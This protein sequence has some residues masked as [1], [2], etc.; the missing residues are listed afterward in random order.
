[1]TDTSSTA[2]QEGAAAT[3]QEL[4]QHP[5]HIPSLAM[6]LSELPTAAEDAAA[7][8]AAVLPPR[9]PSLTRAD[10]LLGR[11]GSLL[12]LQPL[13]PPRLAVWGWGR[14]DC[15]ELCCGVVCGWTD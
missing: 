6:E 2:Q 5:S 4:Q 7:A 8:A 14:N 11:A 9:P 1:M 15:G 12:A 3:Q 10:S 13:Q